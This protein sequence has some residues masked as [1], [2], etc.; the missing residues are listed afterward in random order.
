MQVK[1]PRR[2]GANNSSEV[3]LRWQVYSAR[4]PGCEFLR[5]RVLGFG[6]RDAKGYVGLSAGIL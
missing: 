2:S 4:E 1:L 5:I 3:R 6:F